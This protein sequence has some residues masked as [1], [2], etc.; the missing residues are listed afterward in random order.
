MKLKIDMSSEAITRRLQEVDE[1]REACL[2][3]ADTP[4]G[5]RIRQRHADNPIVKRTAQALGEVPSTDPD[6]ENA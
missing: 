3:L 5:R 4:I 1:L 2:S 6:D